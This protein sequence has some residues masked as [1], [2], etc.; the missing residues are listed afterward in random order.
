VRDPRLYLEIIEARRIIPSRTGIVMSGLIILGLFVGLGFI[1]AMGF[2]RVTRELYLG[3]DYP[4]LLSPDDDDDGVYEDG[5]K[6]WVRQSVA[7]RPAVLPASNSP[8]EVTA[9]AERR[10]Q[11]D[12][13][14]DREL[15][16]I[17]GRPRVIVRNSVW[18]SRSARN[19][20]I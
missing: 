6:R 8:P 18:P 3:T 16:N 5:K 4:P 20:R 7:S 2:F 14:L 11:L 17:F 13:W 1:L 15:E 10:S 12:A 19:N 9:P